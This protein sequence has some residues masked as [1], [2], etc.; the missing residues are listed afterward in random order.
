MVGFDTS[1]TRRNILRLFEK[2][3]LFTRN[4]FILSNANEC[5]LTPQ[6]KHINAPKFVTTL[7]LNFKH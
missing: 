2:K 5:F 7:F 3:G 6:V 4:L 1:P